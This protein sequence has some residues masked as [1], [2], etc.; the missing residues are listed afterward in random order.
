MRIVFEVMADLG[1]A[2]RFEQRLEPRQHGVA[3]ELLRRAHIVVSERHIGRTAR[4]D[5]ER[6]ADDA[7]LQVIERSGLGVEGEERALRER[8][9]PASERSF[10]E[11]DFVSARCGEQRRVGDE[12]AAVR[13][14]GRAIRHA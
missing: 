13:R 1:R 11:H 14:G 2:L 5:A 7:R 12:R 10:I 4:L 9:Q 3:V 8:L 6:H